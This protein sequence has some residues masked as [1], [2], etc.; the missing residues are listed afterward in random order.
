MMIFEMREEVLTIVL[1][2]INAFRALIEDCS[3]LALN[4]RRRKTRFVRKDI[5]QRWNNLLV[6]NSLISGLLSNQS[7]SRREEARDADR[8]FSR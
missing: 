7:N 1:D 8:I 6:V 4:Y 5:D 3:S 2:R